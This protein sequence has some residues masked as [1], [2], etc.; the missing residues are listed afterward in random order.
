[1]VRVPN[2]GVLFYVIIGLDIDGLMVCRE[3]IIEISILK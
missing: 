2:C 3:G 1:M